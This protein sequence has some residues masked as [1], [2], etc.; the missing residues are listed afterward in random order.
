MIVECSFN[1]LLTLIGRRLSIEELEETLF[2]I[3]AE[4]EGHD[5]DTIEIEINPDRQDMLS[6][7]GIARAGS[8]HFHAW[9]K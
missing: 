4:I 2:L 9:A 5:G 7:E 6:P 8:S 3:K 1:N